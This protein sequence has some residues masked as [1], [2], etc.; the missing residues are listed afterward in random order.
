MTMRKG[1]VPAALVLVALVIAVVVSGS[2]SSHE[3]DA[4]FLSATNLVSGARVNAGGVPV[5]TV[6][7]MSLHDG[8]A[9][10]RLRITDDRV[11]PLPT[12]TKAEIR[13]GGTV[14]YSSRYVELLPGPQGNPPLADGARLPTADTV[15]PV[16]FD[17]LFNVFNGAGRAGLASVVDNGAATFGT[18][19][20][21]LHAGL[22]AAPPALDQING[23]LRALGEDPAALQTLVATGA[24]T[25]QALRSRQ[26]ELVD[27]VNGAAATFRTIATNARTTQS[28]LTKLPGGLETARQMLA[29]LDPTLS[30]LGGLVGDIRP[31]AA[32]LNRL[33]SPLRSAI[34]TLGSVA[35]ALG[36]TLATVQRHAPGIANL[37]DSARPVLSK[38]APALTQLAPMA[39]CV[40]P[41]S[42]EI[43][44]FFSTWDSMASYYDANSHYP[45]VVPQVFPFPNEATLPPSQLVK[46]IPN[47]G[48]SLIRPP[49]YS[50]GQ[51]WLQPQCGADTA[52]LDPAQDPEAGR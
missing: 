34:V 37:L 7:S 28:M 18:R 9:D 10:V 29:R 17:Q 12:G 1:I 49:G 6:D 44:G 43:A 26:H 8:V 50:A 3:L 36:A 13:W 24:Q 35:P 40:R 42:P 46:L 14:S 47:L 33:A 5:G 27:L 15:T 22:A 20:S 21:A 2:G 11:W 38:L 45:R 19:A 52:G 51:T 25:A 16:E 31:G 4:T 30:S 32:E 41:Y 39:A 23:V 48:Y